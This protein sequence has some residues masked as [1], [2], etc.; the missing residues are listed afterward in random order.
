M[1]IQKKT[2]LRGEGGGGVGLEGVRVDVYRE[3]NFCENSKKKKFWRGG[4]GGPGGRSGVGVGEVAR[5]G[6]GE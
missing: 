2:F 6:L 5:F 3:V 4:G 1:K